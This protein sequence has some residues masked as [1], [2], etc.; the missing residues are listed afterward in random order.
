MWSNVINCKSLN[1]FLDNLYANLSYLLM[2]STARIFLLIVELYDQ[3]TVLPE[4]TYYTRSRPCGAKTESLLS[5]RFKIVEI[6]RAAK[7]FPAP[8]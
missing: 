8:N 5:S 1:T 3:L 4:N 6:E 2:H 7:P